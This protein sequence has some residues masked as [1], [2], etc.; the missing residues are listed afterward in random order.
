MAPLGGWIDP[1]ALSSSTCP[2]VAGTSPAMHLQQRRLATARR[3]D[4]RREAARRD[5][6][7]DAADGL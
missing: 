5:V 3:A 1:L 7:R 6:G 4:D 2:L